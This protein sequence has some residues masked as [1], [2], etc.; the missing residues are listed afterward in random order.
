MLPCLSSVHVACLA[1]C[2]LSAQGLTQ[3]CSAVSAGIVCPHEL[4]LCLQ[5]MK[6]PPTG[7][8]YKHIAL[9]GGGTAF[10]LYQAPRTEKN[11]AH[12]NKNVLDPQGH[13]MGLRRNCCVALTFK[14]KTFQL[15][16]YRSEMLHYK[17][18]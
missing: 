11:H 5:V 8:H 6:H 2:Q 4:V 10:P 12:V 14:N 18:T 3:S 13:H 7:S 15:L 1:K 16:P 17:V 9:A